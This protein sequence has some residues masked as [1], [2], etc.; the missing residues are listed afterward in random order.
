MRRSGD[1]RRRGAGRRNQTAVSRARPVRETARQQVRSRRSL[2]C[3][4]GDAGSC[5]PKT[6]STAVRS[7]LPIRLFQHALLVLYRRGTPVVSGEFARASAATRQR[8]GLPG[9]VSLAGRLL[10]SPVRRGPGVPTG[11]ASVVARR[12]LS[13]SGVADVGH[14]AA[15]HEDAARDLVLGGLSDDDRQ[16]R[17]LGPAAPAAAGP[18]RYETAWMLLHKLRRAMVNAAREPL[19]GEVEADD[20][21]VGGPQ[22]GLRGSRQLKGRKA[23]LVVVAV[24]NR[25]GVSGRIRMAVI[26]DQELGA[27]REAWADDVSHIPMRHMGSGR[28]STISLRD[29][30]PLRGT[31]TSAHNATSARLWGTARTWGCG[32]RAWLGSGDDRPARQLW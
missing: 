21:W 8:G 14:R 15:Q 4:R 1:G 20:T 22:P 12:C 13:S 11:G 2:A 27:A 16:T 5:S 19:R 29:G 6:D 24:E 18:S 28:M 30:H 26:T 31:S 17:R 7:L 3:A 25:G 10:P 9:P 32:A 23:A